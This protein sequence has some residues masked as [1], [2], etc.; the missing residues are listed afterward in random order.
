[1]NIKIDV[2]PSEL[3]ARVA[4]IVLNYTNIQLSKEQ[5]SELTKKILNDAEVQDLLKSLVTIK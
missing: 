4:T 2:D 5:S 1:M 3:I